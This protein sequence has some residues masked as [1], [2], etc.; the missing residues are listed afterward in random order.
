MLTNG[1]S[2]SHCTSIKE[3]LGSIVNRLL[4]SYFKEADSKQSFLAF[5][6][7]PLPLKL[8]FLKCKVEEKRKGKGKRREMG[9]DGLAETGKK[10]PIAPAGK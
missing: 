10:I 3:C 1:A 4:Q 7:K 9:I 6:R 8:F 2:Y 5:V